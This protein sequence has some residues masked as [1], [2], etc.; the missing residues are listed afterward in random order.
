MI[1][2]RLDRDLPDL[3]GAMWQVHRQDAYPAVWPQAPLEFLAPPQ[4]LGA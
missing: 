2:P 1:R 3:L 4:P